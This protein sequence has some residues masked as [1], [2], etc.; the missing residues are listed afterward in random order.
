MSFKEQAEEHWKYTEGIIRRCIELDNE[1]L[2][3]MKY[4]YVQAMIHGHKHGVNE[5]A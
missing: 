2:E 4:L 5:D 1:T 3:L